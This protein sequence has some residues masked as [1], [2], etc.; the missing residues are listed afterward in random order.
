MPKIRK[1]CESSGRPDDFAKN[2]K[3]TNNDGILN[4]P[5]KNR[6]KS[7]KSRGIFLERRNCCQEWTRMVLFSVCVE[8][9]R[10]TEVRPRGARREQTRTDSRRSR[11][12]AFSGPPTCRRR[13]WLRARAWRSQIGK[14]ELVE[15]VFFW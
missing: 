4:F 5:D 10:G 2:N 13:P 9:G 8:E 3:L 7:E 14:Y 15:N 1:S 11:T 12:S 6:G